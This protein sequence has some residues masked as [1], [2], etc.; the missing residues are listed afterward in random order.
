MFCK[1][2]GKELPD[3]SQ[4]CLKCRQAPGS[5]PLIT[6]IPQSKQPTSAGKVV[7]VLLILAILAW[8]GWR[9]FVVLSTAPHAPGTP[10]ALQSL[11]DHNDLITNSSTTP[12]PLTYLSFKFAVP[13]FATQVSVDGHFGPSGGTGNDVEVF[14]FAEDSFAN[15]QNGHQSPAHYSSLRATQGTINATLPSGAGTYYLVFSNKFSI[16]SSKN[17]QVAVMLH[18]MN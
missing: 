18:Y 12:K 15:F 17:V 5:E 11:L 4:F 1:K 9:L 16:I 14:L 10:T 3:D 7:G 8:V 13:Q 6:S 2:C